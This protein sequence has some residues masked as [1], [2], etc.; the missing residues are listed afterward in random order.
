M[1]DILHVTSFNLHNSLLGDS[2]ILIL[3]YMNKQMLEEGKWPNQGAHKA[4]K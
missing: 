3:L 1:L 4:G 2:I